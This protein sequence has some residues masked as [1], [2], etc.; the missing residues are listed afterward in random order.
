[1]DN[2][3]GAFL[4]LAVGLVLLVA[5]VFIPSGGVIL[6][7]AI[8]SL[9]SALVCAWNAWWPKNPAYFFGFLGTMVVLLPASV[10]FAF[11]LWPS[12]PLGRRAILEA[13]SP[14]EIEAF[15]GDQPERE[16]LVGQAGETV[17]L[18]NPA[19]MVRIAGQRYHGQSE[20]MMIEAGVRV[21]VVAARMNTIVVRRL[22][23]SSEPS[24]SAGQAGPAPGE[25]TGPSIDFEI[26]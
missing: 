25:T 12:T 4:L 21:R 9:L 6:V 5:E 13:P 18:L 1:M 24:G 8:G 22:E 17:T 3:V 7:L 19:G 10:A 11:H 26:A 14:Q 15:A 20:G 16:R 23:L 2:S